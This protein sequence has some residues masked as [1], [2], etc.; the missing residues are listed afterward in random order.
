MLAATYENA[1]NDT[2]VSKAPTTQSHIL[3][4]PPAD[5][6]LQAFTV[7]IKEY[8]AVPSLISAIANHTY[9]IR[10]VY[11]LLVNWDV[12]LVAS[13]IHGDNQ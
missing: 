6:S 11:P 9:G 1:P 12:A 5:Q 7:L 10:L 8:P 4:P 2:P 13:C 3:S